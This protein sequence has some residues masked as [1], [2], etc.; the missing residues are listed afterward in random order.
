VD[1]VA[2]AVAVAVVVCVI[3]RV[4]HAAVRRLGAP[5]V[6]TPRAIAPEQLPLQLLLLLLQTREH[7]VLQH[8]CAVAHTP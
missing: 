4:P 2:I 8:V 3:E 6:T 7:A 5:A 1:V